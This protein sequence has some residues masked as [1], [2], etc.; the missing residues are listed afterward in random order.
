[1]AA[2]CFSALLGGPQVEGNA[3]A[4]DDGDREGGVIL[5][6]LPYNASTSVVTMMPRSRAL[7]RGRLQQQQ[8]Q[9]YQQHMQNQ[10][11]AAA[12]QQQQDFSP[13]YYCDNT[14]YSNST[15]NMQQQYWKYS[16]RES[17]F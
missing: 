17:G 13:P 8:Q 10:R 3:A 6:S 5:V 15:T 4:D 1:M 11:A 16:G 14:D 12:M 7:G 2:R 9:T